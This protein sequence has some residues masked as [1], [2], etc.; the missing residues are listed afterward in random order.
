MRKKL[1]AWGEEMA[2]R[3]LEL[4]GFEI[5]HRNLRAGRFEID[6]VAGSEELTVFVEVKTRRGRGYGVPVEAVDRRK[7]DRMRRAAL[8][9]GLVGCRR[10]ARFDVIAIELG[11][12]MESM[13]LEHL[14]GI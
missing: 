12:G 8:A 14:E 9:T 5:R 11:R 4:K 6:I 7:R 2:A 13:T 1:G 3:F 10:Q